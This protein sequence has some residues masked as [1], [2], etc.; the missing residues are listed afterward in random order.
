MNTNEIPVEKIDSLITL[1]STGKAQS[2]LEEISLILKD[3]PKDPLLFNIQG[4]CY[5]SLYK[6]L[7]ISEKIFYIPIHFH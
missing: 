6:F 2:A 1:Y 7:Y 5:S 3:F 4:A